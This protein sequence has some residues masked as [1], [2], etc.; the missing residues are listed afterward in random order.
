MKVFQ[1]VN[2]RDVFLII[3]FEIGFGIKFHIIGEISISELFLLYYFITNFFSDSIRYNK[4]FNHIFHLYIALLVAQCISE[5]MVNNRFNNSLK[6][7]SVTI[8]SF[9][10]LY[11]LIKVFIKNRLLAM[12]ALVG[13]LLQGFIFGSDID[14][15]ANDALSG[16]DASFLKF[17]I[18]PTITYI[19]LIYSVLRPKKT[20]SILFIYI[21]IFFIIAGARSSGLIVFFTGSISWILS[22]RKRISK[23]TVYKYSL[24]VFIFGY[25]TYFFYVNNIFSGN[26]K[27]GNSKQLFRTEN[28]YNPINLLKIGRAETFVGWQAFMDNPLWGHGSWKLDSETGYKY[29]TLRYQIQNWD[30]EKKII[31]LSTDRIP[32]HSVIMGWGTYNGIFVF[33]IGLLLILFIYKR[34]FVALKNFDSM[35]MLQ[36]FCLLQGSWHAAF[37]PPS[38]F[39]YTLPFYMALFIVSYWNVQLNQ[40]KHYLC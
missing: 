31:Y 22:N 3:L 14:G 16:E 23:R 36:L 40:R 35:G 28:P 6:G 33:I 11:F 17:Y 4:D 37:S 2:K 19:L 7:V 34:G 12:W 20:T 9:C 29:T 27:S 21:G 32:C 8:I 26:I 10:H 38:H 5:I 30:S 24:F 18:A 1:G 25:C 13:I 39:R 15:D